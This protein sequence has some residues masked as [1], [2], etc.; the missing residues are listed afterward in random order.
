MLP[1]RLRTS[2][3]NSSR[4]IAMEEEAIVPLATLLVIVALFM[5]TFICCMMAEDA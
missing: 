1:C 4:N 2:P 3:V 5:T